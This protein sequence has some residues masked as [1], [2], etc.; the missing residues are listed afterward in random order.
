M[1]LVVT[2]ETAHQHERELEQAYRLRHRV[3][4]EERGWKSWESPEG[5]ERDQFDP[6]GSVSF[7]AIHAGE[8]VGNARIVPNGGLTGW[9]DLATPQKLERLR[10]HAP[11]WGLGRFCVAS[12]IRGG[13][14]AKNFGS[15]LFI[16]VLEY[17]RDHDI[18][19]VFFETDP[20]FI[21]LLRLLKV[22]VE[23]VGEP[24]PF[25]GRQMLMGCAPI[26][27]HAIAMCRRMLKLDQALRPSLG[28]LGRAFEQ[29]R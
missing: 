4:V 5:L 3:F 21:A 23:T 1:I 29:L 7:L 17:A 12:E 11:F 6:A 15:H 13:S 10:A 20:W 26:T 22:K 27:E 14:K 19:E 24:L 18:K 16:S 28:G 2:P 9:P 25:Y 8:V